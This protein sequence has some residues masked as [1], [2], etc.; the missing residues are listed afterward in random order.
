MRANN[1][2]DEEGEKQYGYSFIV[3]GFR[4]GAPGRLKREKLAAAN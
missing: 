4:F 3:Q 2:T 1:W